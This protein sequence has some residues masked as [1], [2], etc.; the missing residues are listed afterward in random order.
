MLEQRI[1]AELREWSRHALEKPSPFFKGL[2]ACP[3][4]KTAWDADRVGFVFKTET[5]NLSLYQTIAGFSD[6]FDLIMVVDLVYE[7][8]PERFS[9]FIDS[10]NEAIADGIFGQRD[11]WVMGFHPED[12]P[13]DLLDDGSF[14]PMVNQ[15]YA[16]IFVQRLSSLQE[17]ADLLKPQGY[18]D[19]AFEVPENRDLYRKREQLYRRLKH[20]NEAA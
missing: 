16:I 1:K 10:V 14:S 6:R 11:V 19:D 13:S 15:K 12:D 8:D 5:D 2:P 18:Y 20:G 9:D 4:A 3:Y 7:P 17:K